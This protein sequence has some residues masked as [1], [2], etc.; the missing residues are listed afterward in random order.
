MATINKRGDYQWQAKIRKK[1]FPAQTKTFETRSA[2]QIWANDIETQMVKGL[3]SYSKEAERTTLKEALK[4]YK[5]EVVL[6]HKKVHQAEISRIEQWRNHKF[7]SYFLSNLRAQDLADFRDER[8]NEVKANTVR[9]QLATIS[10]LYTTARQEWGME[11]LVNPVANIRKPTPAQGR[12]RRFV[13]DEESRLF[14]AIN[15]RQNI[16]LKPVVILAIETAMRQGELMSL[17]W[18]DIDLE[19]KTAYLKITKNGESRTVPLSS[20][21]I[22]T[23]EALPRCE[24]DTRLFRCTQNAIQVCYKKTVKAAKLK[25]FTFHDLRHE[26]TSRFFEKGLN[27]MQVASITGHKDLKMLKRYTHLKAADLAE[28]L[29]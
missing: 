10:H 6:V 8:L 24:R 20:T 29:N 17:R 1:G 21:A 18:Q 5:N 16:Y 25:D 9:L 7:G 26:A 19:Q 2:A 22:K 12:S 15:K 3:F 4:R 27:I 28:L 14:D 11:G 13:G 23:I